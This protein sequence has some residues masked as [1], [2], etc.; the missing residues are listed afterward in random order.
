MN[1]DFQAIKNEFA[2]YA[3]AVQGT[4]VA[5]AMYEDLARRWQLT[6]TTSISLTNDV[7]C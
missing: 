5:F 2:K 7:F 1:D 3:D 6:S 4:A